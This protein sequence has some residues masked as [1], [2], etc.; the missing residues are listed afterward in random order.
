MSRFALLLVVVAA[1]PCQAEPPKLFRQRSFTCVTLAE[2]VNHYVALGEE[3][4]A[5]E[6]ESLISDWG[7]DWDRRSTQKGRF[8]I[9]ERV[10]WV[11]RILFIPRGKEPLRAPY[12]GALSLPHNSMPLASWPLYPVA[13]SGSTYFVLSE[14]YSLAGKAEDPKEYLKYCRANGKFRKEAVP[15]PTRAQ[16]LKDLEKLRQSE[17]WKAIKWKDSGPGFSYEIDEDWHW[18][19]IKSQAEK[20]PEK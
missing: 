3:K 10:S 18:K 4:A 16:A 11:C 13:A 7:T 14:G 8:S 17:A 6:L 1:T 5:K 2:A 15:I 20:I 12:Y 9:N 19:P